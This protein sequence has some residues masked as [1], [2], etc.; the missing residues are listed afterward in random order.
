MMHECVMLLKHSLFHIFLK[1]C[2]SAY[3]KTQFRGVNI[4]L[5][6]DLPRACCPD[7][8]WFCLPMTSRN[9]GSTRVSSS[10]ELHARGRQRIL[11]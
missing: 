6:F 2:H 9:E 7:W 4:D 5:K 8:V 3:Y 11:I 10:S 1:T